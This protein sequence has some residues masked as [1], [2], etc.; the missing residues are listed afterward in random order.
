MVYCAIHEDLSLYFMT[1]VEARKFA[2]LQHQPT[3]AIAFTNER[4]LQ[5][6]QLTGKAERVEDFK[7]ERELWYELILLRRPQ[8]TQRPSPALQMFERGS[9]N[10]L[11]I[12]KV[13]PTELTFANFEE[14][15]DGRYKSFF[16]KIL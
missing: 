8:R 3:I 2:N 4:H 10:E 14:Q 12:I 16:E 5:S 1:R 9:T 7:L 13:V 11:A 6:V 15:P